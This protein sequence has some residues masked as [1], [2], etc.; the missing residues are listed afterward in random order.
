MGSA[1]PAPLA[2]VLLA[3][4][5]GARLGR[6]KALLELHGRWMLPS[7]VRALASGGAR[8][9]FVVARPD[10]AEELARRGL[11]Q[12]AQIVANPE[13]QRGRGASL[14][15][16]LARCSARAGVLVHPCDVPLLAVDAVR[17][18]VRAWSE[19]SDRDRIAARLITPG[20]RGGHPLLLGRERA[21]EAR[22]LPEGA[23]LRDVLHRDPALRL[24]LPWRGDP[25]PFLDV[26]TPEQLALIESL[27][28][29]AGDQ[30]GTDQR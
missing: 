21:E 8:E 19:R 13:P 12:P 28:D 30:S 26:D 3:A 2:A 9:V 11:P 25:G 1:E 6:P 15:L 24:D 22:G 4:G 20:G 23:S 27:L 7:L 14:A 29:R 5:S 16:G 18:L 17:A 10:E